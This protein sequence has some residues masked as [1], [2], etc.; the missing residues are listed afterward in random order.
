MKLLDEYDGEWTSLVA[1]A[2]QDVAAPAVVAA[3][4]IGLIGFALKTLVPGYEQEIV[5]LCVV[6]VLVVS[7]LLLAARSILLL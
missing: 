2:A 1:Q 4:V 7:L 3:V 6:A 5:S